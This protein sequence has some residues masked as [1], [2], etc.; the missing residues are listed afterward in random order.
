VGGSPSDAETSLDKSKSSYGL[1]ASRKKILRLADLVQ[2]LRRGRTI[3]LS[4]KNVAKAQI[5]HVDQEAE[6]LKKE[7]DRDQ[8]VIAHL[9]SR[10][11]TTAIQK[12]IEDTVP[13]AV[14]CARLIPGF[15][16]ECKEAVDKVK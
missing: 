8:A 11:Q 7:R 12:A 6:K 2:E 13:T 1:D 9:N 14:I 16:D 10:H 15:I 3:A 4:K 5:A